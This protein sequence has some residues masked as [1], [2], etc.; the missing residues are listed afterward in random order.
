MVSFTGSV[1]GV[2]ALTSSLGRVT[3]RLETALLVGVDRGVQGG[4]S[5]VRGNASGRPGPRVITSDFRRSIVGQAARVGGGTIAGQ[6][7]TNAPQARRL[8]YGF[9]GPD[10]LGRVYNQ[11]P[12]P[13]IEP[14]VPAVTT[15]IVSEVRAAV[16]KA[17]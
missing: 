5:I 14:S 3:P 2:S 8:E 1:S 15:L 17:L 9:V 4:A 6:I 7:G 13:Y 11:P 16:G 12:Y 10:R